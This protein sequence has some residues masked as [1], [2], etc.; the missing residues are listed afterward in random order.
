MQTGPGWQALKDNRY[1]I[2]SPFTL[3]WT[4]QEILKTW[5]NATYKPPQD[6]VD[7]KDGNFI[8]RNYVKDFFHSISPS[9]SCNDLGM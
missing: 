5:S 6:G 8:S 4:L 1:R 2:S 3:Y 7:F 9:S